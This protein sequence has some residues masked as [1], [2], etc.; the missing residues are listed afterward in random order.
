MSDRLWVGPDKQDWADVNLCD[1]PTMEAAIK[2]FVGECAL[3][4]RRVI[5][6]PAAVK[7]CRK[8]WARL[9]DDGAVPAADSYLRWMPR[10]ETP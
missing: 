1:H 10:K 8:E 7:A 3:Q 4:Y 2:A 6:P 5:G 9:S